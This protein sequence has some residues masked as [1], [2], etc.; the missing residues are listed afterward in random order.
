M[1]VGFFPWIRLDEPMTLGEVRLIPYR[2]KAKSLPLN[3]VSKAD[4]DAIFKAY[5]DRPG[6]TVQHGVIVELAGRH[7]GPDMSPAVFERVWQVKEILTLS[8]LTGRHLFVSDG[9]YVNSHAY[10]VVV[11]NFRP[12]RPTVSPSPR[13]GVTVSQPTSG[14][15]ARSRS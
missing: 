3:H 7:A 2:R 4:V 14:Q 10:N 12:A 1:Q 8:A 11:Q 15:T 9:S 6:K 13:G 5:A